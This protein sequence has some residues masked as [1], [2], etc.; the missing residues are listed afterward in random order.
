MAIA[1]FSGALSCSSAFAG[2][3]VTGG[4]TEITQLANNVQLV[5]SYAQQVEQY[6]TQLKQ[7]QLEL[8][9]L[10]Q[11]PLSALGSTTTRIVQG[12]GDIMS[13]EN[14]MGSTLSQIDSNFA[15]KYNSP[16]AANFAQKFK[17]WS[18]SSVGTLG[19]ALKAAGLHRDSYATDSD[20]LQALYNRS[21]SSTGT[22]SAVQQ[23]SSLTSM[24]IQQTQKL[25]DLMASQNVAANTWMLSQ[26]SKEQAAQTTRENLAAPY[27]PQSTEIGTATV[28]N[29]NSA[30]KT[31]K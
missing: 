22:L 9:N 2:G 6:E 3:G 29:W 20:A 13:A 17:T 31:G 27:T 5:L 12:V 15:Q 23:L 16:V 26:T 19:A 21:Q 18:S 30:L 11:N 25:G 28:V 7:W 10:E 4:S 1:L 14:S 24:Q 8:K